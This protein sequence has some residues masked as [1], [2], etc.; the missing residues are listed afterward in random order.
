MRLVNLN[1]GSAVAVVVAVD[2]VVIVL[3]VAALS[4]IISAGAWP[5]G[6]LSDPTSGKRGESAVSSTDHLHLDHSI[7]SASYEQVKDVA[8][9]PET[10]LIDVRN[11]DELAATG[12][13]PSS[14]NIPLPELESALKSAAED[15]AQKYG[16]ARPANDAQIIF[17][18]RSGR[19]AQQAAE[20]AK[21]AGFS[22]LS[23][24]HGSWLE[25]AEK[26]GLPQ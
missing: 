16:R 15:F 21:S 12:S 1:I 8:N 20:I 5:S 17:T 9:H 11:P 24:Y 3:A 22:N 7:M 19:R 14:L 26:E 18:C 2:A 13:I 23:V 6:E 4:P 10:Y 25:W